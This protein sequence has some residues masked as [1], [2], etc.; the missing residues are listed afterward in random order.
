MAVA[1]APTHDHA[2]FLPLDDDCSA[3]EGFVE[4]PSVAGCPPPQPYAWLRVSNVRAPEK[5]GLRDAVLEAGPGL[6]QMMAGR[7]ALL[8]Q[9]CRRCL[10]LD[11]LLRELRD[12]L[13]DGGHADAASGAAGAN[14]QMLQGRGPGTAFYDALISQ[15]DAVGWSHVAALAEDCSLLTL[16]LCDVGGRAH[17]LSLRLPSTFPHTPPS[18]ASY[19]KLPLPLALRWDAA[20]D[21]HTHLAQ[22]QRQ[23]QQQQSQQQQS[24]RNPNQNQ[25]QQQHQNQNRNQSQSQKQSQLN[26]NQHQQ[27]AAGSSSQPQRADTRSGGGGSHLSD[28]LTQLSSALRSYQDLWDCLEDFD[29][30]T[31]VLEPPSTAS[32]ASATR[33]AEGEGDGAR[34][35]PPQARLLRGGGACMR[36][37]IALGRHCSLEVALDPLH[38]RGI[39]AQLRFLGPPDVVGPMQE[40]LA[41]SMDEWDE[42]RTPRENLEAL[43]DVRLPPPRQPLPGPGHQAHHAAGAEGD[44]GDDGAECAICY[45]YRLPRSSG[46]GDGGGGDAGASDTPDV[47]CPTA[48]CGRPFHTACLLEWLRGL[49]DSALSFGMLFGKCPYCS[50]AVSVRACV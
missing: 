32:T 3:F 31:L 14:Q 39:G 28:A 6:A 50:N 12:L 4:L 22:Q 25:Y 42:A 37:R 2:L 38:P 35:L 24:Q 16:Q 47:H 15:L 33:A 27:P 21:G 7:E 30:H 23:Q 9:R 36:R 10:T 49:P 5:G 11:A 19:P 45:A 29:A 40:R 46:G 13:E 20:R 18:V 48:C 17:A 26:Q 41:A 43:L 34:Q 44:G 8:A 1:V